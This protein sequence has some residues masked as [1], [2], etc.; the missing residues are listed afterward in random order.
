MQQTNRCGQAFFSTACCPRRPWFRFRF[1]WAILWPY[2]GSSGIESKE[3]LVYS[4]W[5][6]RSGQENRGNHIG[7]PFSLCI[8]RSAH[9]L[10]YSRLSS[11]AM[12]LQ[13]VSRRRK[14][15]LA[16]RQENKFEPWFVFWW[17][18]FHQKFPW[19]QQTNEIPLS[20]QYIAVTDL[21]VDAASDWHSFC[22]FYS[23]YWIPRS[24]K[25]EQL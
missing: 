23:L 1:R 13:K 22:S 16:A 10:Q 14:P 21:T 24:R 25:Q 20:E 9:K 12:I 8:F 18:I 11:F 4:S 17:E 2:S 6:Y 15:S 5:V 7:F 19:R 3:L